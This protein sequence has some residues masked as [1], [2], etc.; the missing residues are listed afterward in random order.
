MKPRSNQT[1]LP[2]T[3]VIACATPPPVQDSAVA[4]IKPCA[5]SV[6]PTWAAKISI[7]IPNHPLPFRIGGARFITP[8]WVGRNELRPYTVICL[9]RAPD[10]SVY[11]RSLPDPP[12]CVSTHR[13]CLPPRAP[14]ARC[15]HGWCWPDG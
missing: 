10:H 6:A 14:P 7:T 9:I 15:A 1:E 8:C 13:L 4:S 2:A 5:F 3:S 11:P 12:R